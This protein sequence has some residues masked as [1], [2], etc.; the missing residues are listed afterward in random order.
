M[1]CQAACPACCCRS[2]RCTSCLIDPAK[3]HAQHVGDAH[4]QSSSATMTLRQARMTQE[5]KQHYAVVLTY[6]NRTPERM[7][8]TLFSSARTLARRAH[9]FRYLG[10]RTA[11]AMTR[12]GS[13]TCTERSTSQRASCTYHTAIGRRTRAKRA[14]MPS[15]HSYLAKPGRDTQE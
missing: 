14:V 4:E 3:Q 1:R 10:R 7:P 6:L 13:N 2:R 8:V 12:I 15:T 11:A 9:A 5:A